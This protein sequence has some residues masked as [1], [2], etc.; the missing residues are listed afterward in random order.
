MAS[1]FDVAAF[2]LRNTG[3]LTTVK[4]QKLVYYCQSWSL[5]WDEKPL[6]SE[7]IEAWANGPVVPALF[8]EHKGKFYVTAEDF[9]MGNPDKF[10]QDEI[11]TITSVLNH[12][13]DKSAQW[14]VD[15]THL[16]DPWKSTRGDCPHGQSCSREIPLG[17]MM[18]YY[19]GL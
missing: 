4:L 9:P 2:I 10:N 18:E 6:F 17:A 1:V 11:E 3:P 12:Y 19:S 7:R 14:L 13:G 15:L 8:A 5:V 16:E